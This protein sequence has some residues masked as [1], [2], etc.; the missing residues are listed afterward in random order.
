MPRALEGEVMG[1]HVF[2]YVEHVG[3]PAR[4]GAESL[5]AAAGGF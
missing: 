3:D 5:A 1:G 2:K 4:V